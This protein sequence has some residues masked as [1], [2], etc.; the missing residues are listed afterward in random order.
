VATSY[1]LPIDGHDFVSSNTSPE[2]LGCSQSSRSTQKLDF[3]SSLLL[4]P[5]LSLVVGNGVAPTCFLRVCGL[6]SYGLWVALA[7]SRSLRVL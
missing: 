1:V 2:T 3:A 4:I 7:S 6:L 5:I